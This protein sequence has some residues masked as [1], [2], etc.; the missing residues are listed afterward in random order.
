M[1]ATAPDLG[2]RPEVRGRLRRSG[3]AA[4]HRPRPGTQT[5]ALADPS[6]GR[7]PRSWEILSPV[8]EKQRSRAPPGASGRG[9]TQGTDRAGQ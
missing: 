9:A 3:S 6:H 8:R 4:L 1:S 5:A 7:R 2:S